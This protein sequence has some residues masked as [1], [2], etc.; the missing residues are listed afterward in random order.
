MTRHSR[1]GA[2]ILRRREAGPKSDPWTATSLSS[3][4]GLPLRLP[5]HVLNLIPHW[6]RSKSVIFLTSASV[7]GASGVV[8]E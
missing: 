7:I 2:A 8:F 4:G 5:A 6:V 3:S 1:A